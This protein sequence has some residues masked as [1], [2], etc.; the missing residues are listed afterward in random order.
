MS[1]LADY[2]DRQQSSLLVTLDPTARLKNLRVFLRS[3]GITPRHDRIMTTKNGQ[4]LSNVQAIF[5]RGAEIN[6]DLGGKS[7]VFE[8]YSCSLDVRENDDR[9]LNKRIQPIA[10]VE[11]AA[12]WWGETRFDQQS[13]QYDSE[14]DHASPLYLSAAILRG[15][16]TSDETANLV[17]KMV[18]I[19]NT[20]FLASQK[21]RPEQ[22]DFVKSSINWL[23]GREDLIGIGPKK[24]HRHKVTILD[25]HQTF[26]TR[27]VLIFLPAGALL[28]SLI[29]WNMRRA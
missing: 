4:A 7:T 22:A 18:I 12:G 25:A 3:Y 9:L 8:G 10:L 21:T 15:Q 26:I 28:T 17:S 14:E 5:S 11:A 2:W 20:D 23:I 1:I 27:V 29:I 13:A 19:G 24:L 16:A 6:S